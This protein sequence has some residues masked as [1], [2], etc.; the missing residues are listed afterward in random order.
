MAHAWRRRSTWKSFAVEQRALVHELP[1]LTLPLGAQAIPTLVMIGKVDRV[2]RPEVGRRL[3][4]AIPGAVLEE[5]GGGGHLLPQSH[6][7]V[8][9]AAV[10]RLCTRSF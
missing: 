1:G 9:A 6:P 8:V 3:A 2:V 4:A 7:G 5:V 10:R